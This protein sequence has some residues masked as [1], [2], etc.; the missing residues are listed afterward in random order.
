MAFLNP[1]ADR[2]KEF[3]SFVLNDTDAHSLAQ[4]W[5]KLFSARLGNP[6]AKLTL[7]IGCSNAEFLC[8]V[9]GRHPEIAFVGIDW[10]FKVVY[11]GAKRIHRENLKNAMLVRGTAHD[12]EKIFGEG[13]L[14]EIWIFF[15]DPWAKKGQLKKRLMQES[16]LLAAHRA[17]KK[18]GRIFFKT[19]HPGYFQWVLALFGEPEPVL[20]E[21]SQ[22]TPVER[23]MRSRQIQVRRLEKDGL[24][25]AN[26]AIQ[27]AFRLERYSTDYWGERTGRTV[28]PFSETPTLFEQLFVKDGLPIYYVE[29]A[30][31]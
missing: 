7:E 8:A 18:N 4:G 20:P 25:A 22:A 5:H 12:L 31:R 14:D 11:K 30:R 1:Y 9:A 29:L 2:L 23:S 27:A 21:Y 3:S 16:F 17:L 26:A 6:P 13:E 10:K 15:P 19:D 28:T 24:P